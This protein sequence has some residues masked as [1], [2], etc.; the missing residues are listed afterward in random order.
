[1]EFGRVGFGDRGFVVWGQSFQCGSVGGDFSVISVWFQFFGVIRL[2]V[3]IDLQL[4]VC[5][6]RDFLLLRFT[7]VVTFMGIWCFLLGMF[8]FYFQL[9]LLFLIFRVLI[10]QFSLIGFFRGIGRRIVVSGFFQLFLFVWYLRFFLFSF[11]LVFNVGLG[12]SCV[13]FVF[14]LNQGGGMCNIYLVVYLKDFEQFLLGMGEW[15]ILDDIESLVNNF[16]DSCY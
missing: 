11:L 6:L 4:W 10:F 3:G 1:M 8:V 2:D 16:G 7:L 12:I 9:F 13:V 5:L 15:G 14:L